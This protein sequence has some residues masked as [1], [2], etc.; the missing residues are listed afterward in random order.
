VSSLTGFG[1]DNFF[2]ALEKGREEYKTLKF[3]KFHKINA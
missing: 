1:F 3:E 2:K